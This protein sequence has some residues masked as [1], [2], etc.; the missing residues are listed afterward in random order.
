MRVILVIVMASMMCGWVMNLYSLE[1]ADQGS[2]ARNVGAANNFL[3]Y[4]EAAMRFAFYNREIGNRVI[5]F[6]EIRD[7]LP[8][9]WSVFPGKNWQARNQDGFLYVFGEASPYEV[10]KAREAIMSL[11]VGSAV[12]GRLMPGNIEL[13]G[14]VPEGNIV[15]VSGTN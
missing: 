10:E 3:Q 13:P 9:G 15:S 5:G 4:R 11:S 7:Y 6:D 14:F 8:S 2:F 12:N 1:K